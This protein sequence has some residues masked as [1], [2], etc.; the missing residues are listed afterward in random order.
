MIDALLSSISAATV[1]MTDALSTASTVSQAD[2]GPAGSSASLFLR[3]LGIV[4]AGIF[5]ENYVL[6]RFLGIC[7]FLG[8]SKKVGTAVGMSAAVTFVMMLATLV[9]FPIFSML[10]KYD[11]TFLQTLIFII[12]IAALVQLVEII[13][14]KYMKPLY[15]SMGV[16][17]PLITTNCAVLGVTILV[18]DRYLAP[19]TAIPFGEGYASAILTALGGGLGFFVAMLLFAG[20]RE[21]L[22]DSDIPK[23]L[24][25]LPITLVAAS[26]V[27]MSF[28]C[29]GGIIEGL[30][31][32]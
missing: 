10:Q 32:V 22:E 30:G 11:L 31:L 28:L 5:T 25:G 9:T 8:M 29:F 7:P 21:R 26:I 17:L 24:Q 16:Y 13:L 1:S 27:A 19:G 3:L 15:K 6:S 14:K 20:V 23:S 18:T 2:G 12:V 4:L